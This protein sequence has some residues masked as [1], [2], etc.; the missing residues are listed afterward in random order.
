MTPA[1]VAALV[2]AGQQTY[3]LS[4]PTVYLVSIAFG[5]ISIVCAF[6]LGDVK[7]YMTDHVAAAY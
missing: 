3:A 1:Q 4:Y 6:F 5:A 2:A 7:K